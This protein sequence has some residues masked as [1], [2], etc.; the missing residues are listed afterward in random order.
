[1]EP[2]NYGFDPLQP[3]MAQMQP[4]IP[5]AAPSYPPQPRAPSALPPPRDPEAAKQLVGRIDDAGLD[6]DKITAQALARLGG[7]PMAAPKMSEQEKGEFLLDFGLRMLAGNTRGSTT[8]GNMGAAGLGTLQDVRALR[9]QKKAE[10]LA[11][12]ARR[13]HAVDTAISL[14]FKKRQLKNQTAAARRLMAQ[15]DRPYGFKTAPGGAIYG[16]MPGGQALPWR[17]PTGAPFRERQINLNDL[18]KR[19]DELEK[20]LKDNY[21]MTP[22]QK[23]AYIDSELQKYQQQMTPPEIG[24]GSDPATGYAGPVMQDPDTGDMTWEPPY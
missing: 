21:K 1:M 10:G 16:M 6:I 8:A 13:Q 23:S 18:L 9:Q 15:A 24:M 7:N 2:Y 17:T 4:G 19:R 11:E 14:E 12:Q 5:W 20:A 3:P 22:E